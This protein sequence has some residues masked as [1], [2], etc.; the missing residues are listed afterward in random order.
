[1]QKN[2]TVLPDMKQKHGRR[3]KRESK[4]VSRPQS[5][6]DG[7]LIER[8]RLDGGVGAGGAGT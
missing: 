8:R 7:K 5:D 3:N 1:M 2:P 6:K 4:H